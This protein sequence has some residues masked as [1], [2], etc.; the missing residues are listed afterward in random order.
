ML[1]ESGKQ[2]EFTQGSN[3]SCERNV[4]G[5]V[6]RA[7]VFTASAAVVDDDQDQGGLILDVV[8]GECA[9][10]LQSLF[11]EAQALLIG[12]NS[13]KVADL[14]FDILDCVAGLNDESDGLA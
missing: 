3:S 10:L 14:C 5:Y 6:H 4:G 12:W 13:F 9:I 2:T 1:F 11:I 8:F 7:E